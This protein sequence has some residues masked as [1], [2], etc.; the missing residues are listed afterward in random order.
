MIPLLAKSQDF[1]QTIE[2]VDSLK[3]ELENATDSMK[4]ADLCFTIYADYTFGIRTETNDTP[5]Y[6]FRALRI[7]EA[8]A[9]Y[10][11]LGDVHNA[12]GG[13]YYNR[14]MFVQAQEQWLKSGE[15]YQKAEYSNGVAK[16]FNNLSQAYSDDDTLKVY[17]IR[18]AIDLAKQVGDSIIIGSGYNNLSRY[19]QV[20]GDYTKAEEYLVRSIKLSESIKKLS[21]QQVGYLDLGLLKEEQGLVNEAIFYLEKSLTFNA[22]RSTDPNMVNTYE[23]LIRLYSN[24]GVHEKAFQ[25]QKL[26]MNAKDTLFSTQVNEKLFSLATEYQTEKKELI[27]AAQ[28]SEIDLF[29]KE[30]ELRNQRFVFI[31]LILLIGFFIVYLWKSR[32]FSRK[33]AKL[34]KVFAQDLIGNIE[35]ER[36]RI[37]SELHDS[38]GQHLVLLK[39]QAKTRGN[40]EMVETIGDTLEEVRSI[41]QD[42]HPIVLSRLGLTAALEEMIEKLDESSEVFFTR[43]VDDIDQLFST[44]DELNIY[45]IVQE[46][47]NNLIKHAG[48]VSARFQV[49][50]K[51]NRAFITLQDNGKGFSVGEMSLKSKSLG[52]KTLYERAGMLKAK[53]NISS[54]TSGTKL[55]LE[56]NIDNQS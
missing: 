39:N 8:E 27:I 38:V 53:L 31:A 20:Q 14:Q 36:K 17:Y 11:K 13:Y 5:D 22:I 43:E 55:T 30:D 26:L 19:Y 51:G 15:Y 10:K 32:Q 49:E 28:Q 9:E 3:R 40:E 4:V 18:K 35:Q 42:L 33:R 50:R 37:S 29:A 44:D 7:Y 1:A 34:Q 16:S 56:M 6:L 12:F 46:G 23:S 45:R 52:L 41:T 24:M 2:E 25:F 47:L 54:S 21:T 48:A